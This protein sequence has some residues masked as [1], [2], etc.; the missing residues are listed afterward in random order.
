LKI[1]DVCGAEDRRY[2]TELMDSVRYAPLS[3]AAD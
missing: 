3:C 1:T 2:F